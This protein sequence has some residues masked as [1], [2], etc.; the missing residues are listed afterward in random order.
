MCK[1]FEESYREQL[2]VEREAAKARR[3]QSADAITL[4][5]EK[6]KAIERGVLNTLDEN[7][8][9]RLEIRLGWLYREV[10]GKIKAIK[11]IKRKIRELNKIK[12]THR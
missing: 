7:E 3:I 1:T 2:K 5:R 9:R 4:A 12:H 8:I 10:H 11:H 6:G